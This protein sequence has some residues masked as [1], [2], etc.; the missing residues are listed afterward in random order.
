MTVGKAVDPYGVKCHGHIKENRAC[1]PLLAKVPG[2]SFNGVDEMQ[3]CA[4][5]GS[6]TILLITQ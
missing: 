6:E 4:V 3:G 5:F 1:E 2:N